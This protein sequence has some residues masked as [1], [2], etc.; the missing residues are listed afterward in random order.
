VNPLPGRRE[1][2]FGLI[3]AGAA[4]SRVPHRAAQRR[5]RSAW[6]VADRRRIHRAASGAGG[7]TSDGSSRNSRRRGAQR[8]TRSPGSMHSSMMRTTGAAHA[9]PARLPRARQD[10]V[11][12]H[13]VGGYSTGAATRRK[14]TSCGR[15]R[16]SSTTPLP[17]AHDYGGP[18][19]EARPE[20]RAGSIVEAIYSSIDAH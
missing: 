11:F 10:A 3:G 9:E 16:D 4:G 13:G 19:C 12:E 5:S 17:G 6:S 20:R 8:K 14:P 15:T 2:L 1:L 7:C 18:V